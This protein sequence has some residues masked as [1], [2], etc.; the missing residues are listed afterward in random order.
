MDATRVRLGQVIGASDPG[1]RFR[2]YTPVT[3]GGDDIYVHAKVMIVDDQLL[4]VGSSNLNNRSL[5]LDSECDL[6]FEARDD[7]ERAIIGALRTRLMAEHLGVEEAQ[8]AEEFTRTGSLLATIEALRGPGRSLALLP[9]EQPSDAAE[10]I[11][12]RELLDPKS[13]DAMFEGATRRSLFDPVRQRWRGR[14]H[15]RR[16]QGQAT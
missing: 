9:I 2:I 13:P 11:A 8:V 1:N 7:R 10:F 16:R 15:F 5:G 4:R 6:A 14:R 12:D 3:K